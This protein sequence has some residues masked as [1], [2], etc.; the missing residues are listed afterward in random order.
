MSKTFS[1]SDFGERWQDVLDEAH[2]QGSAVVKTE[3]GSSVVVVPM[4]RWA[5]VNGASF[6]EAM[7]KL[8]KEWD[9]QLA[10]LNEPGA[11]EKLIE[12]F[13]STPEEFAEAANAAE[14][15]RRS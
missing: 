9:E 1:A 10:V 7:A 11:G 12:I 3:D 4:E 15:R 14:R 2:T 13:N 8:R 6:D 5:K